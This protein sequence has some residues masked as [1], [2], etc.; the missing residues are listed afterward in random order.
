VAPRDQICFRCHEI[1]LDRQHVHG[2]IASGGCL[3]CH[4]PHGSGNRALLVSASD[5]FCFD[6]HDRG[7]VQAIAG[8]EGTE[9]GCTDCHDAHAS[10]SQSLLK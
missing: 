8:H 10:D 4:D 6:C 9:E 5:S 2:P 7:V 3:V 1:A